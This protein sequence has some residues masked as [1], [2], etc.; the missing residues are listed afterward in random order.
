[1][2]VIHSLIVSWLSIV[3]K[4]KHCPFSFLFTLIWFICA[5]MWRRQICV[6]I[7]PFPDKH[8]AETHC[9]QF[10]YLR[11]KPQHKMDQYEAY[12]YSLTNNKKRLTEVGHTFPFHLRPMPAFWCRPACLGIWRRQNPFW[13]T[14]QNSF[15]FTADRNNIA[16]TTTNES[17]RGVWKRQNPFWFT[18]DRNNIA[19]TT[20]N[21]SGRGVWRRQNP[22]WFTGQNSFWFTAT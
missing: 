7:G 8:N 15:W 11:T 21:E 10:S 16:T 5:R 20:T 4:Q 22:F 1:M 13:F 3:S 12:V 6:R 2:H 14:R 19:T 9:K 18:A 17:G